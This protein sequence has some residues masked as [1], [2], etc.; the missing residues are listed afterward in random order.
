METKNENL[1]HVRTAARLYG[2]PIKWLK[3][4]AKAGNVPALIAENQVLFNA[5][6]L[7]NWLD[8]Q[9]RQGAANE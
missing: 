1:I 8:E 2:L 7:S 6:I 9:A 5:D 3:D 4:Q